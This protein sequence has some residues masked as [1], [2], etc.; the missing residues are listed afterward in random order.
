[1]DIQAESSLFTYIYASNTVD[2]SL[3]YTLLDR[4]NLVTGSVNT[5]QW[6]SQIVGPL[7]DDY[8]TV[9]NH[10]DTAGEPSLFIQLQIGQE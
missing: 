3:V 7:V 5:N 8:V 1:V 4:T 6:D 10:Y 9:S 2:A